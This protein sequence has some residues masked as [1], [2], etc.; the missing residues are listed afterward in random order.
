M[1]NKDGVVLVDKEEGI[2]SFQVVKKVKKRLG[3]SK[4][5]HAGTL[6]KAAT[7]L[8]VI[9]INRATSIQELLMRGDKRYLACIGLGVQTDTLDRYGKI[10][11]KAPVPPISDPQLDKVLEKFKGKIKQV[12]PAYSA[13]HQNG[14]RMYQRALK[15]EQLDISPRMVEIKEIRVVDRQHNRISMDTVVSKG[16]YLRSLA[17]DLAHSLG[18]CGYLSGLRRISSGHFSVERACKLHQ[19]D[20]FTPLINVNEALSF[21]PRIEVN[22]QAAQRISKGTPPSKVFEEGGPIISMRGCIRIVCNGRLIAVV[23]NNGDLT[24]LRVFEGM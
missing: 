7:G 5:G 19:I 12:P 22:N 23:K 21:L 20:N 10:I 9:C 11:K 1:S 17:R 3:V 2:T 6:D 24:Y 8:L 15:G 13:I 4:A 18:T 16:T 14:Q